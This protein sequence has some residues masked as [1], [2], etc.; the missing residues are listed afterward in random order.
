MD[1]LASA[2]ASGIR[3]FLRTAT[4]REFTV[5]GL[6]VGHKYKTSN[7]NDKGAACVFGDWEADHAE[8]LARKVAELLR[9]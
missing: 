4:H 1:K 6:S 5:I 9:S 7:P 3:D 8:D 2:I